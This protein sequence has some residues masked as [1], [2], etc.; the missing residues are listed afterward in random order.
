MVLKRSKLYRFLDVVNKWLL[1]LNDNNWWV[2][3]R[4][5]LALCLV[6]HFV[7]MFFDSRLWLFEDCLVII[8]KFYCV[9]I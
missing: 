2:Q 3:A 1:I 6:N 5:T 7:C 8:A 4:L 9:Y